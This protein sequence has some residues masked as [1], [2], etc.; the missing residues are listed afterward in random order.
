MNIRRDRERVSEC[1]C[2]TEIESEER[3]VQV[4]GR[5]SRVRENERE[6]E[7]K[8]KAAQEI[9]SKARDWLHTECTGEGLRSE[10]RIREKGFE[11]ST[12][13]QQDLWPPCSCQQR[14]DGSAHRFH[15]D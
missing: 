6:K 14:A 2:Q 11:R 9:Y 3:R 4:R 1:V 12:T 10:E 8:N 7:R 5:E 13:F 15:R